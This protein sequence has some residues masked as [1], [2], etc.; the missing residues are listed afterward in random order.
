MTFGTLITLLYNEFKA[1]KEKQL[2]K[3]K[4]QF[5]DEAI[6]R[7]NTLYFE[8]AVLSYV[9]SKMLSKPKFLDES[10]RQNLERIDQFLKKIKDGVGT[11][12]DAEFMKMIK[13]IGSL[14]TDMED[15]DKRYITDLISKGRLKMAATMYAKGISIG[16]A[17]EMS[18]VDKHEIQDYAGNTM[19]FD[20]V[21]EEVDIRDRMKRVRK[22]VR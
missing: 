20:R 18:G 12:S 21:K 13:E 1:R 16:L 15:E 8:F 7:H 17:A 14:V 22:L 11:K 2:R 6:M 4:D 3:L 19:I 5:L 9:L 10:H